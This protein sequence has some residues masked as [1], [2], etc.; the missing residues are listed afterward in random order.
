MGFKDDNTQSKICNHHPETCTCRDDIETTTPHLPLGGV[1]GRSELL[2][3]YHE[4]YLKW[5]GTVSDSSA[6]YCVESFLA[7]NS[8]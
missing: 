3:A 2:L 7:S 4:Y 5:R 6:K 1:S 8:L